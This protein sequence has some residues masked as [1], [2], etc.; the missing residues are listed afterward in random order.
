VK[1]HRDHACDKPEPGRFSMPPQDW[2]RKQ[3]GK[4]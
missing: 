3:H 1:T 4:E 2:K